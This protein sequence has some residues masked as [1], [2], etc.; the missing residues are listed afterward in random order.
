VNAVPESAALK[1]PVDIKRWLL[2]GSLVLA[3]IVLGWMAFSLSRQMRNP[4]ASTR[5]TDQSSDAR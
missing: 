1:R 4:T 2:W 5:P 3:A